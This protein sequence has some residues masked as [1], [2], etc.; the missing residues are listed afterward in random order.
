MTYDRKQD[1][2]RLDVLKELGNIGAGHATTALSRLLGNKKLTLVVPQAMIVGMQESMG[3][4]GGPES[5]VGAIYIRV[6]G[7]LCGHMALLLPFTSVQ[8]LLGYLLGATPQEFSD[9]ELSTLQE[10]GNI[11][12]T[13]YLNAL[14]EMTNTVLYP[15]V[16]AVAVDMA[17]AV[18]SSIL[19]G[20][21]V[22]DYITIVQTGFQTD[23][24]IIDGTIAFI[25]DE[26]DLAKLLEALGMGEL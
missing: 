13:S 14:A 7:G 5:L 12:V 10:V 21:E 20:A 23:A 6:S 22:A 19:A 25:P 16:P 9:M 17:A 1:E 2:F 4:C 15:S 18:W 3:L 8:S 11:V 24:E 26:E